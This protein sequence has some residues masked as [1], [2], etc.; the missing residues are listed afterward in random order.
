[1]IL[2]AAF[3]E[4][5]GIINRAFVTYVDD[6]F[7]F[8]APLADETVG[9]VGL[10]DLSE[11]LH[12]AEDTGDRFR[13]WPDGLPFSEVLDVPFASGRKML[14]LP[15]EGET[16]VDV[17][18]EKGLYQ[19]S[20]STIRRRVIEKRMRGGRWQDAGFQHPLSFCICWYHPNICCGGL[21]VLLEH[22]RLGICHALTPYLAGSAFVGGASRATGDLRTDVT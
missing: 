9:T 18:V 1:M 15:S 2:D 5:L 22:S 17:V 7:D 10:V 20:Q 14:K 4:V 11:G 6:G 13:D 21:L 12:G 3:V 16:A 8:S 19:A